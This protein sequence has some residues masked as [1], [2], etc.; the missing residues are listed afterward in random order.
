MASPVPGTPGTKITDQLA[1]LAPDEPYYTFEVFPPKT[2]IGTSNLVD[3]ISRMNAALSPNWVHVTWGAGGSTQERSLDLVAATKAMGVEVC[4]H[5]TATNMEEQVLESSLEQRA[6]E[7]GVVNLLA[8]RGDPPRGE[9][10]WTA[11]NDQFH[12]ATDLIKYIRLKYGDYFCIGVAGY[13]EG[14]AD[15]EDKTQD[16]E[17]LYQKQEA[18]AD[19]VVTQLFY[20]VEVFMTWYRA[21]RA[22]GITIPILP[23]IMPIQNYQSF[24]RM[25]NL[26]KSHIP[27]Q[28]ISE[29]EAIQT[30]DAAVKDYGV[31]LAVKMM[32]S[33]MSQ[34]VR[35]YHLC[36]LNLEKSV[37]RVLHGLEWVQKPVS[38]PST[39]ILPKMVES[40][41]S[42]GKVPGQGAPGSGATVTP[43]G[44][45]GRNDSPTSWDEFP[46]GRFGDARS[47]AYGEMDGYGVGLKLPPAEALKQW[48]YPTTLADISTL[49]SS[50]LNGTLPSIPWSEE[51]LRPETTTISRSLVRL[52]DERHWWTVGS[53]PAVDGAPSA[54]PIHGFG[55]KGGFVYQKAFVEFF[56]GEEEMEVFERRAREDEEQRKA[57]GEGDEG[58]VKF[59][60][61]NRRGD[62]RTNMGKGDVNA[63]TWGVFPGK[64]IVT[65]TLIEE[66]SFKAW[67]E[68][69]FSIWQEWS[70]LYPAGS[71]SRK[72]IQNLA[73][74]RW[75]VSVCHHD[76]KN[77]EALW[78]WLLEQPV[79]EKK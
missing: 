41:R 32:S 16:I 19:F 48:G 25:T 5:L 65:T 57:S 9:E 37:T 6:K 24:R 35:G 22:R 68:E 3:R 14:H 47:P 7:L 17:Y 74:T 52:N 78:T 66:M 55:P 50:Y 26:C 30:D 8:L 1:K 42:T 4:L 56:L 54:H 39:P 49:F 27:A 59:F 23:G 71:P 63:V 28:I 69:A 51:A 76:F 70:Y 38:G 13:P 62:K 40:L 61:G 20:D 79:V 15:S 72:F 58:V 34:G 29:L 64:E 12:H 77:E 43:A 2:D 45:L 36:T 21:C 10:Y 44:S 75:L 18:G 33:L 67:K 31:N 60:A 46:N 11:T 73:D 53:Q